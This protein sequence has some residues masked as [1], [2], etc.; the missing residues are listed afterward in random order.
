MLFAR[1]A[2]ASLAHLQTE[3]FLPQVLEHLGAT[4]PERSWHQLLVL[5]VDLLRSKRQLCDRLACALVARNCLRERWIVDK[6]VEVL[7]LLR[8]EEEL[9]MG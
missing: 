3:A 8:C 2:Q 7:N 6:G 4:H 9:S 1:A 5:A